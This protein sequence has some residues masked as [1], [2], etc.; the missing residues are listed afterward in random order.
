MANP[1]P[2]RLKVVTDRTEVTELAP[3]VHTAVTSTLTAVG[4]KA[5][6]GVA[7]AITSE[8]MAEIIRV[9]QATPEETAQAQAIERVRALHRQEYGTCQE[10]THEY[11]VEWPCPTIRTLAE[12]QPDA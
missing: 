1:V 2:L 4:V 6:D 7:A 5:A 12:E 10:C 9:R 3:R 11:G 8:I